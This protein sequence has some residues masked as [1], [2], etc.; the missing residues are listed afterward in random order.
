MAELEA[1][2][3]RNAEECAQNQNR[4]FHLECD[5]EILDM[6]VLEREAVSLRE[7]GELAAKWKKINIRGREGGGGG[8]GGDVSEE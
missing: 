7:F 4:L 6:L 8:G 2:N 3:A 5:I 1:I